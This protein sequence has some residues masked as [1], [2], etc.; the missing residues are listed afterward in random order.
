ME[1]KIGIKYKYQLLLEIKYVDPLI[2]II[3]NING[4]AY[5]LASF[6]LL[7]KQDTIDN[8]VVNNIVITIIINKT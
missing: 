7:L 1:L 3:K 4:V 5:W 2:A 8:K 6:I